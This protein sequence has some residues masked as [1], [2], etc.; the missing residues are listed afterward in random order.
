MKKTKQKVYYDK[1]HDILWLN[2][3]SGVEEEHRGITPDISLELGEKGELLG[4]EIF[5]A[6]QVLGSKLGVRRTGE[7]VQSVTISH[8]IR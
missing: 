6:S 1:K 4:I 7:S 8:R 5:N 2:I 3:K